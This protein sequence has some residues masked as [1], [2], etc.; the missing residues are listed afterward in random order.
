VALKII[1][2][3]QF[4]NKAPS[5]A[6]AADAT[7]HLKIEHNVWKAPFSLISFPSLGMDPMKKCPHAQ[8]CAFGLLKYD[9]SECMFNTIFDA[10]NLTTAFG[11]DAR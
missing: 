6:S 2:S 8:L 1:P 4:I 7:T 10:Q 9:A 3:W 5:S 11:C